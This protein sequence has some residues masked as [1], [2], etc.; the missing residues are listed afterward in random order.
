MGINKPYGL[1]VMAH[2]IIEKNE[3][4]KNIN[5]LKK[6][7]KKNSFLRALPLKSKYLSEIDIL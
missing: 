5:I 3:S 1:A 4:A 2:S 6:K 7:K